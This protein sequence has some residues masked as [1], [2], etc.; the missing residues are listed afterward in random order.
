M[1]AH[2]SPSD[3]CETSRIKRGAIALEPCQSKHAQVQSREEPALKWA[4]KAIGVLWLVTTP[5]PKEFSLKS[6]QWELLAQ[7]K[8]EDVAEELTRI[9]LFERVRRR[10]GTAS[11]PHG[12]RLAPLERPLD[13]RHSAAIRQITDCM[14]KYLDTHIV[15]ELRAVPGLLSKLLG[16]IP[17]AVQDCE[18]NIAGVSSRRFMRCR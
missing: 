13:Q 12:Y 6:F 4:A 11:W 10:A 1:P 3:H 16:G 9:G 8:Q 15:G 18:T 7:S 14:L 2:P 17:I 5:R